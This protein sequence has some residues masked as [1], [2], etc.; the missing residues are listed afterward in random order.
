[1]KKLTL[2]HNTGEYDILIE[3]GLRHHWKKS[4]TKDYSKIILITDKRVFSLYQTEIESYNLEIVKIEPGEI[5]KTLAVFEKKAEEI[6]SKNIPRDTLMIAFGG[7]VV[8]D[9]TGFLAA[10]LLRGIDYIQ[11]P[12]TL[13]SQVDSSI[14]GKVAVNSI[15]GKNLIGAFY[16]PKQVLIDP[17]FLLTLPPREIQSGFGELIKHGM[18]ADEDLFSVLEGAGSFHN[19][20][21]MIDEVLWTSLMIKKS[22]VEGDEFDRGR[23]MILNF[24][25]TLGHAYE[26]AMKTDALAHGQA[27]GIGMLDICAI[28]ESNGFTKVGTTKRLKKLLMAYEMPTKLSVKLDNLGEYIRK[29]KKIFNNKINIVV[30][31]SIGHVKIKEYT[32]KEFIGLIGGV[33]HGN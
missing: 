7:G 19:L 10:T 12:T 2:K 11:M 15:H 27:V 1:M 25:H 31:Q 6:L 26:K 30:P 17:E 13:L 18:I 20:Y 14:G 3:K 24:G 16:Q 29:D 23:R 32:L 4:I 28:Y 5:S 9:F 8:G 22:I 21:S 33:T